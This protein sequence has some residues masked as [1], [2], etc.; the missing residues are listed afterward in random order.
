MRFF[1]YVGKSTY[2]I[3]P[4][5]YTIIYSLLIARFCDGFNLCCPLDI[6]T[7]YFFIWQIMFIIT[8]W[9][10]NKLPLISLTFCRGWL[11]I[12]PASMTYLIHDTVFRYLPIQVNL[13]L[14]W[15]SAFIDV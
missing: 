9:E 13:L 14:V 2:S 11:C 15:S 10:S 7:V 4:I 8:E 3:R 12:M 1:F 6:F 5:I